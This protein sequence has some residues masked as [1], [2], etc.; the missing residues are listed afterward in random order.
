MADL[1][2]CAR[3]STNQSTGNVYA[4]PVEPVGYD[5]QRLLPAPAPSAVDAEI[6][7]GP[8]ID[9]NDW[10][11]RRLDRKIGCRNRTSHRDGR[12]DGRKGTN[13][14]SCHK[15]LPPLDSR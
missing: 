1:N 9:R 11:H 13:K 5:V 15:D 3:R 8:V 2:L 7:A 12:E 10:R 6:N 4:E 14:S